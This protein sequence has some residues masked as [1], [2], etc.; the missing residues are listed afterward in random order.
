MVRTLTRPTRA[1]LDCAPLE[2]R[3]LGEYMGLVAHTR[4]D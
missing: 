2:F 1:D 3:S 4:D